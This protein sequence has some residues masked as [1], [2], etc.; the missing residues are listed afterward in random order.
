MKNS[1][2]IELLKE[3]D[4]GVKMGIEAI[5]E[6][7]PRVDDQNLEKILSDYKIRHEE[8]KDELEVLLNDVGISGDEPNIMAK[9]M[10]KLKTNFKMMMEDSDRTV[11]DLMTDGCDMGIKSLTKYLNQYES[12]EEKVKDITKKII[13]IESDFEEDLKK[14]L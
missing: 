8:L 9:G 5:D 7:M 12:A 1:D 3:C 10:S 14:Y 11:A 2:T 13:R 6:V 4:Q